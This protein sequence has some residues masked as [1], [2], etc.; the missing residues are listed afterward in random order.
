MFS[1]CKPAAMSLSLHT[2]KSNPSQYA[3]LAAVFVF[4]VGLLIVGFNLPVERYDQAVSMRWTGAFVLVFGLAVL[5]FSIFGNRIS[6]PL[7]FSVVAAICSAYLVYSAA[8][9]EI[10][11]KTVYHHNFLGRTRSRKEP[12]TRDAAPTMFREATN[13]RW[14][15]GAACALASIAAFVYYRKTEYLDI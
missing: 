11:G 5:A 1:D 15:L 13:V 8:R 12:V 10:T 9:S 4:G 3:G 7:F 6:Q 14:G 2:I